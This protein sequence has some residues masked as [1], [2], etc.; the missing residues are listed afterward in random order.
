[1]DMDLALRTEQPPPLTMDSSA[2]AKKEFER[3]DRSNHMSLMIIK[4]G[5]PETFRGIITGEVTTSKEF[6]DDNEKHF[7][8]NDK[9]ETN[10]LL[11][12]MV[13]L[14]Y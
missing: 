7:V 13:S 6:L 2:E 5:I 4:H 11:G 9:A 3:W 1:M 12:S 14:K 8:N 10:T